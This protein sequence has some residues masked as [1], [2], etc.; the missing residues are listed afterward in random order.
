MKKQKNLS[1]LC[2]VSGLLFVSLFLIG[3]Q[4]PAAAA[5]ADRG[6]FQPENILVNTATDVVDANGGS[7]PTLTAGNLPG[8]DGLISLR[9]A[10]CAAN[11]GAGAE[12]I[13]FDSSLNGIPIQLTIVGSGEADNAVGDLDIK[14]DLTLTGNGAANTIIQANFASDP[15]RVLQTFGGYTVVINDL[16]LTGGSR[17]VGG[18]EGFSGAGILNLGDLTL[19]RVQVTGNSAGYI[20]GGIFGWTGTVTIN[21]S[22]IANNIADQS[23]GGIYTRTALTVNNST[24]SGNTANGFGGGIRSESGA[25]V[26]Y[27]ATIA[28]N[29]ADLDG[30]NVGSGGGI[31]QNFD[32][33]TVTILNTIVADNTVNGGT[34]P[35]C[36]GNVASGDYNLLENVTAGCIVG[37][38]TGNNLGG[39][40][41]LGLLADNGGPTLTK[42]I[43][44][45]SAAVDHIPAGTNGCAASL[46]VDQRGIPRPLNFRCDIGA[47]ELVQTV[48]PGANGGNGPGGV[49][50]ADGGSSLEAW[51]RADKGAEV[52]IGAPAQ[53]T[54]NVQFW[55]DQSGNGVD[56]SQ[57]TIGRRPNWA[58]ATVNG[59]PALAYV[60]GDGGDVLT[61][62]LSAFSGDQAYTIFSVFDPSNTDQENLFAV[63][64]PTT[65][66]NIAY[67][68]ALSGSRYLYHFNDDLVV[69][70]TV[71]GWQLQSFL[72]QALGSGTDRFM[73]ANG[74]L[75]GS[76]A[77]G[78]LSIPASPLLSVGGYDNRTGTNGDEFTGEL[79]ELVFYSTPLNDVQRI[80][81]ENYLSGKYAVSLAANDLFAGDDG[82]SGDFDL[83]IAGIGRSG[84]ISHRQANAAGMI[85]V[86]RT[87][88]QDDGDWLLFGHRSAANNNTTAELPSGGDWTTAPN[89]QR[90]ERHFYIDVTD[91]PTTVDCATPG[92][93]LVDIVFDFSEGNMGFCCLPTGDPANYRL[94]GRSGVSGN[95]SDIATATAVVGDQVQ[96]LGVDVTLLG[97][98]FT[99]GTLDSFNSPTAIATS[100]AAVA[101]QNAGRS[102]FLASILTL[103]GVSLW[104]WRRRQLVSRHS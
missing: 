54:D 33:S 25:T 80:L 8:T 93:C 14:A 99:F 20:G 74:S 1:W 66:Q 18:D 71:S 59:Q 103:A 69:G 49:G 87:F 31:S 50:T 86:D 29:V 85:V 16:T 32:A 94:L 10:I 43:G 22:T 88:L 83:D 77:A 17:P 81:V 84:G 12:T 104:L 68:P 48:A 41:G 21:D 73:Y 79:A 5:A 2:R 52:S 38:L 11:N 97:S 53:D 39:D 65:Q 64:T 47:F 9:E 24:I 15:D 91:D 40:P 89:P 76:N 3:I 19:N 63:G 37:G 98:N 95:F 30:N 62:I 96:F 26:L 23:G 34:D 13:Q 4:S 35:E 28:G 45:S 46:T 42:E 56:V 44:S 101:G 51:Y 61:A 60:G 27:H 75:A 58:A 6:G 92:N 82:G 90:W 100:A 55:R 7:C 72:Y 102:G 70:S 36:Y 78:A 57:L 67:H